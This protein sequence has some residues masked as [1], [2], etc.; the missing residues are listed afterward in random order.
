MTGGGKRPRRKQNKTREWIGEKGRKKTVV[1]VANGNVQVAADDHST[2]HADFRSLATP[3][4]CDFPT[5]RSSPSDSWRL[6]D[7]GTMPHSTAQFPRG[8]LRPPPN[9]SSRLGASIAALH[10][11]DFLSV[12]LLLS[13]PSTRAVLSLLA[14]QTLACW[15]LFAH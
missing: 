7:S 5:S 4:Q 6:F 13:L 8:A 2:P 11:A 15:L 3:V 1:R 14:P 12:K 9:A 10:Q